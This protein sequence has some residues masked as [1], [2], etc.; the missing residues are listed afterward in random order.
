MGH[1]NFNWGASNQDNLIYRLYENG[2]MVQ[3]NIAEL[4]FSLTMAGK[5]GEFIYFV[6]AYNNKT[7]LES[8]PSESITI[9]FTVPAAPVG[10][11]YG[12]AE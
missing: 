3:D 2:V 6:T 11:T 10:L 1:L 8:L 9:N 7:H 5:N 4:N 12:W